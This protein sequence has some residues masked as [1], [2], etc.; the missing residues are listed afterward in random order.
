[1]VVILCRRLISC[2]YKKLFYLPVLCNISAA[3]ASESFKPAISLTDNALKHLNKIR[4]DRKAD[5]CLRIGVKQGGCSGMSY[6]MDFEDRANTRPDDSVIEYDGFVIGMLLAFFFASGDGHHHLP[7]Y[8]SICLHD[9]WLYRLFILFNIVH[10]QTE[11]DHAECLT[12]L[13]LKLVHINLRKLWITLMHKT[14]EAY[15]L[16]EKAIICP[17]NLRELSESLFRGNGCFIIESALQV[18]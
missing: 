17:Y 14:T 13:T 16:D 10:R 2:K 4:S 9:V 15:T 11:L 6:M 18:Q 12:S 3:V 1:M 7:F 5:I 8:F